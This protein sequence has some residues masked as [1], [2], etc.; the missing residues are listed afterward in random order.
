[1]RTLGGLRKL[2]Y[3]KRLLFALGIREELNGQMNTLYDEK[4]K[5]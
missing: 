5:I 2:G 1:M 4:N 3:S